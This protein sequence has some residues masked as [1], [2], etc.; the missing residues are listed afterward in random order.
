MADANEDDRSANLLKAMQRDI[1]CIS[2]GNKMTRRRAVDKIQ[3]EI[4]QKHN[5]TPDELDRIFAELCKPLLHLYSFPVDKC[6]EIAVNMVT[7]F[8]KTIKEPWKYLPYIIPVLVDRLG[9]QEIVEHTEEI[10]FLQL[11]SLFCLIQVCK[12]HLEPY[13]KDLIQILGMTVLDAFPDAKKESCKCIEELAK[14]V[15]EKFYFH[16][17]S[18]IK[19]LLMSVSHQHHKVRVLCLRTI[20]VAVKE[21]SGK[22]VDNVVSHIAQ[23]TFD[24]SAPVRLMVTNIIG[25]WL[26]NLRDRY[27]Y[28]HKLLPLLLTGLSDELDDIKQKSKDLFNQVGRQYEAE[29]E[30]DL[31]DKLDFH[32]VKHFESYLVEERPP[33]GC[34]VLIQRNFSKIFPAILGDLTD[35]VIETRIKTSQLLYHLIF[36]AEDH[37]T[38]HLE[39]LLQGLYKT[40]G[41]EEEQVGKQARKSAQLIGLFVE[42]SIYCK[43]VLPHL[44]AVSSSSANACTCA[45]AVLTSLVRGAIAEHLNNELKDICTAVSLRDVSCTVSRDLHIELNN[46][47]TAVLSKENLHVEKCSFML[48]EI[49]L[50]IAAMTTE[51][52]IRDEVMSNFRHF[53]RCRRLGNLAD[54]VAEHGV[55]VLQKLKV[56]GDSWTGGSSERLVFEVLLTLSPPALPVLLDHSMDIFMLNLQLSKEPELRLILFSL[57]AKVVMGI[58]EFE[59]VRESVKGYCLRLMRDAIL[60]NCVWHAGRVAAAVRAAAMS[61]LWSFLQNHII[62][63]QHINEVFADLLTQIISCLDDDNQTTRAVTC[64]TILKLLAECKESFDAERLHLIYPELMKRMDDSSEEIRILATRAFSAYF[65]CFTNYDTDFYQL[66]LEAMFKGLLIHLDDPSQFIQDAVLDALKEAANIHPK[67]LRSRI[68]EVREKHRSTRYCEDLEKHI[69][70]I[71]VSRLELTER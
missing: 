40:V 49:L 36:Y 53:V 22:E 50:N 28:F 20:G 57:L 16:G 23:R 66:H 43:L 5:L 29:N 38:M 41:D 35:W 39:P 65:K 63:T 12:G 13:A 46:F 60:P 11:E 15:P 17:E 8:S 25:D 27:S 69:E 44:E 30:D 37:V 71:L 55:E 6:R 70:T 32:V 42:P 68:N 59:S 34:R 18:L 2:D 64:K 54:L 45:V 4:F 1:N 52:D 67:L 47:V 56:T 61:C 10:R 3:K 48:F 33:L 21:T 24:H 19:P 9:G 31:K 26:L 58:G 51:Q 14:A 7:E 62:T